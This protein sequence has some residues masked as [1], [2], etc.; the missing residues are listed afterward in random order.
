MLPYSEL[1]YL[2]SKQFSKRF[3]V[4]RRAN[5][6]KRKL[7]KNQQNSQALGNNYISQ[8]CEK[9]RIQLQ[10]HCLYQN[11]LL[12]SFVYYLPKRTGPIRGP[13]LSNLPQKTA[14]NAL[15]SSTGEKTSSNPPSSV[16]ERTYAIIALEFL[17]MISRPTGWRVWI[18]FSTISGPERCRYEGVCSKRK[19]KSLTCMWPRQLQRPLEPSTSFP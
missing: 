3:I 5:N 12:S 1:L 7:F 13:F 2:I 14:K 6:Y 11:F 19:S 18:K 10:T 4:P 15:N 8:Q 9:H 16:F 17:G